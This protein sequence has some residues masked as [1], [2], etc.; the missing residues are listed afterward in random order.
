MNNPIAA[1]ENISLV[2]SPLTI[3]RRGQRRIYN[4]DRLN[5]GQSIF[6][7]FDETAPDMTLLLRR[8][9]NAVSWAKRNE[10]LDPSVVIAYAPHNK[11]GVD[12]VLAGRVE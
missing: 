3:R 1:I 2:G 11:D 4:W 9:R 10:Q 6:V 8:L 5:V 7:P 12:G